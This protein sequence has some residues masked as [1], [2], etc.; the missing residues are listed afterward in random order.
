[1]LDPGVQRLQI[2][3]L[4]DILAQDLISTAS[5][6]GTFTSLWRHRIRLPGVGIHGEVSS[7]K[8]ADPEQPEVHQLGAA[9]IE[10]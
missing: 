10:A 6:S 8:L 1:M 9:D 2:L 3:F 4:S 7:F 5:P